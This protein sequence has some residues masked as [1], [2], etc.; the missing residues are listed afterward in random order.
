[1]LTFFLYGKELLFNYLEWL[2]SM[3]LLIS[4]FEA[5]YVDYAFS[6]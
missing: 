6:I 2:G 4:N 3:V 5:V 1:M